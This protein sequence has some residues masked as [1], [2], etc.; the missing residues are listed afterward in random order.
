MCEG[1]TVKYACAPNEVLIMTSALYGRMSP[2]TCIDSYPGTMDCFG[3]VLSK[4]DRV[5][6][7]RPNCTFFLSV[8]EFRSSSGCHPGISAYLTTAH[9]C[10]AGRG[11]WLYKDLL[12]SSLI[13]L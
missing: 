12:E 8:H 2:S 1:D 9:T 6:S 3:D 11:T 13:G 7:G 5:C 4:V 10:I